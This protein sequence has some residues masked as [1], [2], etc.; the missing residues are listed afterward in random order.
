MMVSLFV[1]FFLPPGS[2]YLFITGHLG[3]YFNSILGAVMI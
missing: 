3:D 2:I 1:C